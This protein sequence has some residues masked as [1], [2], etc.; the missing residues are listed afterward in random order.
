MKRWWNVA[1]QAVATGTQIYTMFGAFVPPKHQGS[2]TL[3]LSLA[4]AVVG[5][6]AH[7]VNPDGT[8]SSQP[9]VPNRR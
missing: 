8:P 5:V 2:V 4:Q 1:F 9:Y 6:L 7:N 3:G